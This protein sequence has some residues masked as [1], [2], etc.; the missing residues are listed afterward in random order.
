M[1]PFSSLGYSFMFDLELS[2][3]LVKFSLVRW[4]QKTQTADKIED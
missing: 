3:S 1:R 2:V 4:L